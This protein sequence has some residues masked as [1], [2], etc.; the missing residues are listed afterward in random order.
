MTIFN[1]YWNMHNLVKLIFNHVKIQL[2]KPHIE[3]THFLIGK[4][5]FEM[6]FSLG[7]FTI[8]PKVLLQF[9]DPSF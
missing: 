8:F 5:I 2:I 6:C 7:Y 9:D 3:A 4:Y 1:W